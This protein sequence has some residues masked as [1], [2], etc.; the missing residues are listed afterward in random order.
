MRQLLGYVGSTVDDVGKWYRWSTSG[1]SCSV[2]LVPSADAQT[3]LEWLGRAE[4]ER[5]ALE[6]TLHDVAR[7]LA[8]T[9]PEPTGV[10]TVALHFKDVSPGAGQG[11]FSQLLERLHTAGLV[12]RPVLDAI[13]AEHPRLLPTFRAFAKEWLR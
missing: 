8:E 4:S 7:W 3:V 5:A 13:G 1:S 6:R 10:W 11:R 9:Q 12:S 2:C